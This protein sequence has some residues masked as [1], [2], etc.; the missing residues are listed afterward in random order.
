MMKM[1][2][3]SY[4][5]SILF[6]LI[7]SVI[8]GCDIRACKLLIPIQIFFFAAHLFMILISSISYTEDLDRW[9]IYHTVNNISQLYNHKTWFSISILFWIYLIT[10]NGIYLISYVWHTKSFFVFFVM[11]AFNIVLAKNKIVTLQKYKKL[12][13]EI[14]TFDGI[15]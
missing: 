11:E 13:V 9:Y 5:V 10:I 7:G 15:H 2:K 4:F 1:I 8:V 12:E 14:N 3:F 6:I